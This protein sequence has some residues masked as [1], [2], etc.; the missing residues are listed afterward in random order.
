MF[1]NSDDDR[2]GPWSSSSYSF[3]F[4]NSPPLIGGEKSLAAAATAA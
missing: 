4:R 3:G 2:L 1:S